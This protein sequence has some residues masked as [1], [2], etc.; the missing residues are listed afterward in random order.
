MDL[1]QTP[2]LFG[3]WLPVGPSGSWGPTGG[4]AAPTGSGADRSED[5]VLAAVPLVQKQPKLHV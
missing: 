1:M 5:G 3:T 2:W 4:A